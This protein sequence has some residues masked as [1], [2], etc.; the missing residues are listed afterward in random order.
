[1]E[2]WRAC[3]VHTWVLTTVARGYRHNS[4]Q[5]HRTSA[6]LHGTPIWAVISSRGFQQVCGSSTKPSSSS[7]AQSV[8]LSGRFSSVRRK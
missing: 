2:G 4:Q 3:A 8:G 1:L 7:G 6:G 5:D